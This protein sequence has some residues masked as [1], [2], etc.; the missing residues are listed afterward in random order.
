MPIRITEFNMPGQRSRYYK[1]RNLVMTSQEEEL[2]AK[3]IVEYYR[4]CFAHPS[5]EGILMWGFWEGANW[6]PVSSLYR[7]DWSPTPAAKAYQDLIFREWW[8]KESGTIGNDGNFSTSAFFGKY[9]VT[10]NGISKE[11]ALT[12]E[13]GTVVLD[14]R[15]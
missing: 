14:L 3:E 2:K 1:D 4:I 7:R 10:V 8:T 13:N 6:I 9:I 5:V 12:R 15:K 11:I